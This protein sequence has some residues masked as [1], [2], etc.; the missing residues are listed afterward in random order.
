MRLKDHYRTL[1]VPSSAAAEDIRKAF[2]RLAMEHHPDRNGDNPFAAGHFRE[3]KEAYSVLGDPAKR[4]RYDEERWLAGM[5]GRAERK[6]GI[7]AAW[8]LEETERLHKHMQRIDTYRMSHDALQ[9][10][11]LLLLADEYMA[12]LRGTDKTGEFIGK[13]M[14]CVAK[15][16]LSLMPP[17]ADRLK[18]LAGTDMQLIAGIDAMLRE[19]MDKEQQQKLFPWL[20]LLIIAVTGLILYAICIYIK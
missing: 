5:T 6:G 15:L 12:V 1:G 14:D 8:V 13:V 11:V 9:K 2:R 17:I 4:S 19:R 7:T 20:I 10:Y 18:L 16:K 3:L